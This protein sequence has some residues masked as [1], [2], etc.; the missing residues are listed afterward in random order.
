MSFADR[1]GPWA[2][3]AGAS[4]GLGLAYADEVASR[5]LDVVMLAEVGDPLETVAG[6]V[7]ERHG[8]ETRSLVADLARPDVADLVAGAVEGL[9]VGL[10]VYNAAVGYVGEFVEADPGLY[11]TLVDVNCRGAAL[12]CRLFAPRLVERGR[13]GIVVMGSAAGL[14]GTSTVAT[15]SA[16]KAF[17]IALGEALWREL[18]PHGVDVVAPVAGTI[19][20]PNLRGSDPDPDAMIP[21]A[22][23]A[24]VAVQALDGLGRGP[25]VYVGDAGLEGLDGMPRDD[26]VDLLGTGTDTQYRVER[27]SHPGS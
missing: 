2:L 21:P 6:E 18:G 27:G 19:D 16:S 1:Y 17:D 24:R 20:T 5:G 10:L 3:V 25:R 14:A 4:Q 8:V 9:D 26:L 22:A 15:Y 11:G 7:A 13:G 12:L 23:P